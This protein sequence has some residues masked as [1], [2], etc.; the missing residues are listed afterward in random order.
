MFSFSLISLS[1]CRQHRLLLGVSGPTVSSFFLL[2]LVLSLSLYV[3]TMIFFGVFFRP[4]FYRIYK[5]KSTEGFQSI[6]YSVALFSA[7]L[8]LYYAFL[9]TDNQ[10]MLI[11]I[12]SV[13]TCIEATYLLMYMIYA[14][15]PAKVL[16]LSF[17]LVFFTWISCCFS[18]WVM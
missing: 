3:L 1:L 10:I 12:N 2:S 6:P 18:S 13:G 7:M 8:L 17:N 15:R 5:R 16:Y 9:K 4:T 14:P 11:T